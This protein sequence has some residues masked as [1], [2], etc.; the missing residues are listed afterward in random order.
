[1]GFK[2]GGAARWVPTA[3]VAVLLIAVVVVSGMLV[4][5]RGER[6]DIAAD[7]DR[8]AAELRKAETALAEHATATPDERQAEEIA[9]KYAM[10]AATVDYRDLDG[11]EGRMKAGTTPQ[12][13]AELDSTSSKLRGI[14]TPLQWVST[15]TLV[16]SKVVKAAD[17]VFTVD[18][19]LDINTSNAQSSQPNRSTVYYIVTVD[20]GAQWLITDVSGT[21]TNP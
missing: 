7:R 2:A 18:V 3:V 17:G 8:I 1:M 12:L 14:L 6:A 13:S 5:V 20:R 21:G 10:G 9:T 19:F 16:T 4:S 15:P 11:W